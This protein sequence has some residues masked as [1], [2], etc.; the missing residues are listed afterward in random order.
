M[1]GCWPFPPQ[2]PTHPGLLTRGLGSPSRLFFHSLQAE[3]TGVLGEDFRVQK[4]QCQGTSTTKTAANATIYPT[5]FIKKSLHDFQALNGARS[6]RRLP[7]LNRCAPVQSQ[8]PIF[9]LYSAASVKWN[10]SISKF[11]AIFAKWTDGSVLQ[12]PPD[13]ASLHLVC[14]IGHTSNNKTKSSCLALGLMNH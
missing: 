8:S 10:V 11:L 1:R 2:F 7:V 3:H 14:A 9:S 6:T 4:K 12:L 5:L 13:L